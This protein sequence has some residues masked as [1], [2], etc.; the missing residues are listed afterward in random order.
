MGE[1]LRP[2]AARF[3]LSFWGLGPTHSAASFLGGLAKWFGMRTNSV[4]GSRRIAR[5]ARWQVQS[6]VAK[7]GV[8]VFGERGVHT[9][10][11]LASTVLLGYQ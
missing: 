4:I 3:A 11:A 10:V 7:R 1:V 6:L 9:S 2:L 8:S 5:G